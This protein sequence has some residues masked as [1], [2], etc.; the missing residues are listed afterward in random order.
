MTAR[1]VNSMQTEE[2]KQAWASLNM[3]AD[4]VEELFGPIASMESD[5]ASLLRGPEFHHRAAGII[6]AL[7][8]VSAHYG[9]TTK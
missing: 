5:E 6:E 7:Q 1:D 2:R 3:I 8:R 4:A 9:G